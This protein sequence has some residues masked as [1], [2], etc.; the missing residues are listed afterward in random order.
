MITILTIL[1][2]GFILTKFSKY[3]SYIPILM[4][5][6][7]A[8]IPNDR[9][10]LPLNKFIE[11]LDYLYSNNFK[12][13][14]TKQLYDYYINNL[15]LPTKSILLTFDDGYEDNFTNAL[16]Y[17]KKYN[18]NAIVFP[19]STWIGKKNNWE[20]F[21]KEE[22]CTM[23]IQ[24]L[25]FWLE[26]GL[27]IGAHSMTHP[28]LSAC[29]PANLH[30]EIFDCK[31]DLEQILKTPITTFCYPYG[32]FNK[33]VIDKVSKAKYQCA[34]AIFENAPIDKLNILSLPRIGISS[35]QSLLE[36]KLKV[37]KIHILFIILRKFERYFK[38]YLNK[39][40]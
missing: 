12:T 1:F 23:S 7:I 40:R 33:N 18:M 2:L 27:E 39:L 30:S 29:T 20:Q 11:Q 6:R 26:S 24:Q 16:P 10:S 38:K 34:F 19:I 17:L 9:N 35:R 4:Y 25:K 22:T 28:F 14:T 3:Q 21:G 15:P 5:H 32:N 13:I 31:E 36:F 8:D 37:S